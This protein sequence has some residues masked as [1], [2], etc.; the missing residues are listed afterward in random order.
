M[1]PEIT[2]FIWFDA[3]PREVRDFY[4]DIFDDLETDYEMPGPDGVP[5]GVAIS[6]GGR[7]LFLFNGGPNHPQTIA[8]SLAVTAEGQDQVDHYWAAL[9]ADGGSHN[10]CGWLQD[11]YGV[12]WQ[13]WPSVLPELL[14]G[15]DP[16]ASARV[17]QA[18]QEMTK[19]IVADLQAAYDGTDQ[20]P[21]V[22]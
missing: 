7:Q 22:S 16:A 8:F 17:H 18:V 5:M 1:T 19:L 2:P 4:A 15:P 3:D 9:A 10:V 14:G 20:L 12:S 13:I 21:G 6:I 11:K